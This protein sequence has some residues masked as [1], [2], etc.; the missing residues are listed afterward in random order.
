MKDLITLIIGVLIYLI[1]SVPPGV[2]AE[3][4]PVE[5]VNPITINPPAAPAAPA[6]VV[7]SGITESSATVSWSP[8][9]TASGYSVW[10]DGTR[11]TGSDSPG[12]EIKGLQPGMAYSV[13]VTASNDGGESGPSNSAMFTTLPP[14]PTAPPTP[15]VSEVTGNS[16]VINWEPLQ[17]WQSIKAYR[18]YVDGVAVADVEPQTGLQAANLTNLSS[19]NHLVS[20]SGINDNREGPASAP[21][22]FETQVLP[23]INGLKMTNHS[24]D[25]IYLCW[26]AVTN[27]SQYLISLNEQAVG[28]TSQ[29]RY[30]VSGLQPNQEYQI[31][32]TSV[33]PDGNQTQ[34]AT[35]HA[36]TLPVVQP[37]SKDTI[38]QAIYA[39]VPD[40]MPGIIAVFVVGIAFGLARLSKLAIGYKGFFRYWR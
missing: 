12:V 35:L 36:E 40:I 38:T 2:Y 5:V 27:A 20:I 15:T 24:T 13:Y 25:T 6:D 37:Y 18:V 26:D 19:G 10:V 33:M 4:Q 21:A 30:A 7:V 32:V 34:A 22:Q 1:L 29:S 14:V 31:T 17:A 11:W 3:T 16:A 39:Y 23:P 28:V 8:A 9:L